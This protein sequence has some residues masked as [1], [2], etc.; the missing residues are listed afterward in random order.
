[1]ETRDRM[2]SFLAGGLLFLLVGFFSSE[3]FS[4]GFATHAYIDG[5]IGKT[6]RFQNADEIYGGVAPDTFNYL[7]NFPNYLGFL[8]DQTHVEFTKLWSA[9]NAGLGKSLA[10]G[11]ASHND[12]WGA[13]STAHHAGLTFGQNVGYANAKA[14]LLTDILK[15]VPEYASLGLPDAVTLEIS[16]ELVEDGVDLL[17][18]GLDPSIG[19]K[20]SSSAVSR[21]SNFPVLLVKA[22]ARD[23]SEFGGISYHEA[24]KFIISAEKEFRKSIVLYGQAMMQDDATAI[25]LISEGTANVAASFLEANGITLPSGVD[26]VPLIEFAI[27]QSIILCADDFA[28]EIA[29]T[30]DFVGQNLQTHGISY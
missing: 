28:D 9:S 20:L 30:I 23:F 3:A 27:E 22:Y 1:M 6:K 18:K 21:T 11:F 13:D 16:H 19:Q 24:S 5:H 2:M 25:R 8:S 4:W 10:F 7:F 14:M 12:V 26:I 29:A 17:I 15:Q